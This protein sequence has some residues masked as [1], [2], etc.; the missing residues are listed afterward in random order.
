MQKIP[1]K[2]VAT[3]REV[4]GASDLDNTLKEIKG[5][6]FMDYV[7]VKNFGAVG[8]GVTDDTE[9]IQNALEYAYNQSPQSSGWRFEIPGIYIPSGNYLIKQ[10][11][12]LFENLIGGQFN[13]LGDGLQNTIITYDVDTT[14]TGDYLINNSQIFGFT[15]FEGIKFISKNQ[16]TGNF[17][18]MEGGGNGNC[19]SI[20]FENC[21][22]RNFENIFNVDGE[23]MVS[24]IS[25]INCKL[26]LFSGYAFLFNNQQAVNWRFFGTE[27]ESFTG[28][29]FKYLKGQTTLFIQGSIIPSDP[30]AKI[31]EIP[32][33]SDSNTFGPGNKPNLHFINT[34]FEMRSESQMLYKRNNAT[35]FKVIFDSC[36]M[37]G[38][39]INSNPSYYLFDLFGEGS[40]IINNCNNFYNYNIKYDNSTGYFD[41]IIKNTPI[42]TNFLSNSDIQSK[43][44][45][46]NLRFDIEN[47]RN[48]SVNTL[49]DGNYI[50][51]GSEFNGKT[52]KD[53]LITFADTKDILTFELCGGGGT[54]ER[55]IV[56]PPSILKTIK[57]YPISN[58]IYGT[59]TNH[60]LKFYNSDKT[61]ILAEIIYKTQNPTNILNK[62]I[63]YNLGDNN[64]KIIIEFSSDYGDLNESIEFRGILYLTY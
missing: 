61:E 59:D 36:G 44:N 52:E 56:L 17:M 63:Y 54:S 27:I 33:T 30:N 39:N 13:I 22:F 25:F 19:Q 35:R 24:E 45:Q 2:E 41:F 15:K 49:Y 32:D 62:D 14:V 1:A 10:P 8:D 7:N 34:R 48:D 28:T 16:F 38:L 9:A 23:S 20:I 12:K 31:I 50:I 58:T 40:V 47:S 51:D 29:V 37:G 18:L 11:N 57:F 64:Q 4:F 55:E 6:K 60:T 21:G 46:N 43:N 5:Q 42:Y 3:D 53:R 26:K